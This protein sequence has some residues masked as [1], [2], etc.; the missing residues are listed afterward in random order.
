[1]RCR[2]S[3]F[4]LLIVAMPFAALAQTGAADR[5]APYY[6]G[7]AWWQAHPGFKAFL[8]G[9]AIAAVGFALVLSVS[10]LAGGIIMGAGLLVTIAG[11]VYLARL[12]K[13]ALEKADENITKKE[14]GRG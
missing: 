11:A 8:A 5:P 7:A 10:E 1:M 9:W 4:T 6:P 3:L 2:P 13:R 14:S 12:A